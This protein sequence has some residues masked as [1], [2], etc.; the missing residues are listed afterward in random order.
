MDETYIK[1]RGEWRYLYRAVDATGQTIDFLLTEQRDEQAAMRFLTK[2]IRRQGVPENITIDGSKA[3]AAAIR[4]YNQAHDT[5]IKIRQVKYLNNML[6]QDHRGIKPR[7]RPMGG[8]KHG[9]TAARFCRAFDEIRAF[10]RPQSR[11]NQPLSL[12]QRRCIHRDRFAQLMGM[13]T[14]A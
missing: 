14:A 10:L 4:E 13:M 1:E 5:A 11:R 9:H 12:A 2:A 3:N 8:F 6:E 7:Y